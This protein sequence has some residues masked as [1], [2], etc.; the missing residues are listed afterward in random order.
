MTPQLAAALKELS[1][2]Q[3]RAVD[4]QDG[5]ALVLAGPGAGKTRVLTTRIARIL[6]ETDGKNFRVLAL[7]FTTKAAKEMA[8]RIE[9][10]V[11]GLTGRTFVGTFHAFCAQML[12]LHGSHIGIKPDFGIYD[13]ESDRVELLAEALAAASGPDIPAGLDAA[14]WLKVIDGLKAAPVSIE[15]TAARFSDANTGKLAARIYQLYE[16]ALR[17]RNVLDFN[18]LVLDTCRLIGTVPAVAARIRRTY[19]YWLIDE[20]QD[21]SPAQYMLIRMLAGDDFKNVFAVADDDQIIYQWAGASYRQ[22]EK[23]RNHFLPELIQLVENHRCPAEIVE[24]ANL[25]VAHNTQRTP[26]KT[27]ILAT[28]APA[29][30]TIQTNAFETGA[31]ECDEIAKRIA[32]DGAGSW[33]RTAILARTRQ[34][35]ESVLQALR[36][37][38][39][40]AVIS[41]RRD[42]YVSPEFAWLQSMLD[43][44]IRP[45]DRLVFKVLVNAANRVAKTA[46]D[47]AS[48]ISEAE[49]AGRTYLEQW[50][51]AIEG[52]D[53]AIGRTLAVGAR[54]LVL[55]RSSW[56][57]AVAGVVPSLIASGSAGEGIISDADEDKAAWDACMR[58]IRTEKGGEPE[59]SEVV[60]GMSLRSKE[61]P[62]D[63]NAVV[64][65]T[66]HGAKG[67]EF[68]FVYVVG[69]AESLLPSWQSIK[70]G[71][72]SPQME[73]E[74]RNC[75]VAIT[76]TKKRLHLSWAAQYGTWRKAP[77][78]FLNEMKL[79]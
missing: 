72:S 23:Y 15:K 39:V 73:E 34:T 8:E 35:L 47:P 53:L 33:G 46:L 26:D 56:K 6:D 2:I 25:L 28:H 57:E 71:D 52:A 21:T 22:I 75:F 45:T 59:L 67:L 5:A 50:A 51:I 7:T 58:E 18:G 48:L 38:G 74:R 65:L 4:W 55:S 44:A 3:R 49:A 14:R 61:P 40:T 32:S 31:Q 12:S 29:T 54:K 66:V 64:L 37:A 17:D 78:R 36:T 43:Q 16:S 76:R 63:S 69:L 77:S 62:R 30:G 13:Q 11:P 42:R 24:A 10:L 20:F 27:P 70:E 41:Q 1:P 19:Q 60:Q 9:L 79:V 68:D